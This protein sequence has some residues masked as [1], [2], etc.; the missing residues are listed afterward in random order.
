MKAALFDEW[1][2]Y[3]YATL[4]DDPNIR[5]FWGE[6]L[7]RM[8]TNIFDVRGGAIW[9][10]VDEIFML[11]EPK[12]GS[13]WWK[14]HAKRSGEEYSGNCVGYGEWGIID[15]WRRKKPEYWS[16]RKAYSLGDA[17]ADC[18]R[19]QNAAGTACAL[20]QQSLGLSGNRM[21]KLQPEPRPLAVL[22]AVDALSA[23]VNTT[24]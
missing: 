8:W 17:G 24:K 19:Q 13:P 21:G 7:D 14:T 11:P 4:R 20:R 1:A 6:S 5:K 23:I 2:H 10:Y 12:A 3:T 16:V 9:R 22:R 18:L 15:V